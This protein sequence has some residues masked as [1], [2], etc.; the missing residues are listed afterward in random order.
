MRRKMASLWAKE[1]PGSSFQNK[2]PVLARIWLFF[3]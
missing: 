2:L 1:V 3:T